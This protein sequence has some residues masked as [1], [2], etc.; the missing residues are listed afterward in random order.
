MIVDFR[1]KQVEIE[2]HNKVIAMYECEIEWDF[3][4]IGYEKSELNVTAEE[5]K[6][7]V[8]SCLED[9]YDRSCM[10]D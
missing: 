8:D 5:N 7:I 3:D 4:E 6:R 2:Y 9:A 1:G 10:I